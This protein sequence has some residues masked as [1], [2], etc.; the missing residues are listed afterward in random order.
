M[1]GCELYCDSVSVLLQVLKQQAEQEA[2]AAAVVS[3][4]KPAPAAPAPAPSAKNNASRGDRG[5]SRSGQKSGADGNR[6][7]GGFGNSAETRLKANS[8]EPWGKEKLPPVPDKK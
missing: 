1:C 8:A 6:S 4:P 2:A 3:P 5:G 7:S